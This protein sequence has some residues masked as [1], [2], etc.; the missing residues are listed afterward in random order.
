MKLV[1]VVYYCDCSVHST[2]GKERARRTPGLPTTGTLAP[3]SK[4]CS[5]RSANPDT[6]MKSSLS[7]GIRAGGLWGP[8]SRRGVDVVVED[9]GDK[10]V[11]TPVAETRADADAETKPADAPRGRHDAKDWCFIR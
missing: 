7:G 9:R 10:G 5:Q 6:E 3:F 11:E 8:A 2:D 4:R 1:R